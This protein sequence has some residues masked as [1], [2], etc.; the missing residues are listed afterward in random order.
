MKR[1][2]LPLGF[3]LTCVAL[4][5]SPRTLCGSL[6][7]YLCLG[8]S[9]TRAERCSGGAP[10]RRLQQR[11]IASAVVSAEQTECSPKIGEAWTR[12]ATPPVGL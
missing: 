10:R 7:K 1:A 8:Q 12:E 5:G 3:A 2:V 6:Q 9:N 4:R 11:S